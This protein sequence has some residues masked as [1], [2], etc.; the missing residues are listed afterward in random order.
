MFDDHTHFTNEKVEI[1]KDSVICS[2]LSTT[3]ARNFV[4]IV[5]CVLFFFG[6]QTIETPLKEASTVWELSS[7]IMIP[8]DKQLHSC[9][10]SERSDIAK[11]PKCFMSFHLPILSLLVLRFVFS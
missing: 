2:R 7:H 6:L 4:V 5:V 9:L 11:N 3:S 10:T 1:S 8:E